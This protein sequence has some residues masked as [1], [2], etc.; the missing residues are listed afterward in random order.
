MISKPTKRLRVILLLFFSCLM[1]GCSIL[2]KSAKFKTKT[3]AGTEVHQ[4]GGAQKPAAVETNSM[5]AVIPLPKDST[6]TV[7]PATPATPAFIAV[8]LSDSS[9]LTLDYKNEKIT[10][11]A[12]HPPPTPAEIA[13]GRAVQ[14]Y[15]FAGIA[16]AIG[17]LVAFKVGHGKAGGFLVIGAAAVPM[18]GNFLASEAAEKLSIFIITASVTLIAAWHLI[19]RR[20]DLFPKPKR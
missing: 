15:Y 13:K 3:K 18:L 10:G 1:V 19:V 9:E 6:V 20:W 7:Q 14:W 4:A 16:F 2:P 5:A 11:P 17:A 12:S 8:K